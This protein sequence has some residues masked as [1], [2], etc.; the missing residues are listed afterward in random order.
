[1]HNKFSNFAFTSL[2]SNH[3]LNMARLE[4]PYECNFEKD[5]VILMVQRKLIILSSRKQCNPSTS[6]S[7]SLA[8]AT[9]DKNSDFNYNY[10]RLKSI[11][12]D[13]TL[14][15]KRKG[16]LAI[17]RKSKICFSD[18]FKLRKRQSLKPVWKRVLIRTA[19]F[20]IRIA[21][22]LSHLNPPVL[23]N[24]CGEGLVRGFLGG[25]LVQR[26]GAIRSGRKKK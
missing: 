20:W 9:W 24:R 5:H 14:L 22:I 6:A 4:C 18:Y 16:K 2:F 15:F 21:E 7:G 8:Q 3:T 19:H 13:Y 12:L 1:M 23:L 25:N 17:T 11:K 10:F 26:K